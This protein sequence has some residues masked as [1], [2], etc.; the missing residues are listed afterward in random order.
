[1]RSDRGFEIDQMSFSSLSDDLEKY[2]SN[3]PNR[4]KWHKVCKLFLFDS[5]DYI[6]WDGNI[7]QVSFESEAEEVVGPVLGELVE[8]LNGN[9]LNQ[10]HQKLLFV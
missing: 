5:I 8:L 10:L 3:E 1:M 4:E 7:K 6:F 9:L 2:L